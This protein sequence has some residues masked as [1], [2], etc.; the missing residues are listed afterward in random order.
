MKNI[1]CFVPFKE[2][3]AQL[4]L[5]HSPVNSINLYELCGEESSKPGGRL[6]VSDQGN[7]LLVTNIYFSVMNE[8]ILW[9]PIH[10]LLF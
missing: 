6:P 5:L 10:L 1:T 4:M 2:I 7:A 9:K 8:A 3:S